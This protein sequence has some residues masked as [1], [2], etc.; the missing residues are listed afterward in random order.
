M[1]K[2]SEREKYHWIIQERKI[3]I[4]WTEGKKSGGGY[5]QPV[6]KVSL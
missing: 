4:V 5:A 2:G 3:D 1:D 6:E